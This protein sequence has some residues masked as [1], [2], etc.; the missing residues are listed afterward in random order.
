MASTIVKW[1]NYFTSHGEPTRSVRGHQPLL[2]VCQYVAWYMVCVV[3]IIS[4]R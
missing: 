2:F 3:L 4:M 1:E